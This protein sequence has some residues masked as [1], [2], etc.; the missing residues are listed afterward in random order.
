MKYEG[1]NEVK[2]RFWEPK[3]KEMT[4]L[5]ISFPKTYN[6]NSK[7]FLRDIISE[8]EGIK[9]SLILMNQILKTQIESIKE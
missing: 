1:K 9:F 3:K 5:T 4:Y 8:R 2:Y 6:E 7:I